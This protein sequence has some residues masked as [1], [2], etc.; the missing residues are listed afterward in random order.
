MPDL[1]E[2]ATGHHLDTAPGLN[3]SAPP[4]GA[5]SSQDV[6]LPPPSA[7]PAPPRI[8]GYEVLG[9][10]GR[11][12]MGVVYQARHRKLDRVCALKL[13]ANVALAGPEERERFRAEARLAAG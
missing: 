6:W 12:G 7:Q 10:L 9:E 13:I 1:P 4:S 8:D 5:A 2:G 3:A 11:G